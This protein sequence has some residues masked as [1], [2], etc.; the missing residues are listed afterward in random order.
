M[1]DII[2]EGEMQ[3]REIENPVY[4]FI[5]IE[6]PPQFLNTPSHLSK[7]EKRACF[8]KQITLFV[9]DSFNLDIALNLGLV[10]KQKI[11]AQFTITKTGTIT[12]LEIKSPHPIF[13]RETRRIIE[14]LPE[15]TPAKESNNKTV[16]LKYVLQILLNIE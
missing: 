6:T 16:A 11:H 7:T 13:E 8:S 9:K 14:K 15:F 4:N 5:N 12:D 3:M 2:I 10:G 1:G